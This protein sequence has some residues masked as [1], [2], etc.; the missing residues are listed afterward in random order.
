MGPNLAAEHDLTDMLTLRDDIINSPVSVGLARARTFTRVWQENPGAPWIV[1]KALA[2]REHLRTVGLFV[3]PCD[4]LAGSIAERPGAMPLFPE[5][6]I[7]ENRGYGSE[8]PERE[9]Y[10][11]GQVPREI[12][13]YWEHRNLWGRYRAYIKAVEGRS[14]ERT[15]AT[16]YKF[17]CNQGHLSPSYGEL[18]QVGLGGIGQKLR[19]RR[20]GE[21]DV[22]ALAFLTAAEH[23]LEGLSEWIRRY[24]ELLTGQ[25]ADCDDPARRA[26]LEEMARICAKVATQPPGGFREAMQLVWFVHQAVHIEGHGYS[27]TPDR[28]DQILYPF[29]LADKR[30]GRLDD[31]EAL[32]LCENFILKQRDNTF[33]GVE[34]NLTQG[35]VLS[36][37]T[38]DGE[39]LTN[40]LSWLFVT[41]CGNMSV[42]EPLVWIRWHANIDPDFFDHCLANIAGTT[43][44][45]LM[46]SDQAVPAML[47]EL[48]VSREDAFEY[49]PVGCNEIGIVGKAYFNPSAHVNYLGA[50][51]DAVTGG[52]G[53][54]GKRKPNPQLPDPAGLKTFD[55]LI[56]VIADRMRRGIQRTYDEEVQ[57]VG[58]QIRY[59]VTPL[60]SCFFDG[61]IDRARDMAQGTKYNILS[62]GGTNF[63]NMIDCL[64]AIR[65]V[66]FEKREASLAEIVE[67]CGANFEGHGPLRKKLLAAPKH[68][69]DDPG[70]DDL[71]RL[72]ERLRDEPMKEICRDP[73]D[74]SPF[75]NCHVVRSGAVLGGRWWGALPDGRLAGTPLAGSVA[76]SAGTEK[77]GPTA[78]LNSITKMNPVTSWQSGYNVNIR[79]QRSMLEVPANRTKIRAML[80]SYFDRGG[81][82]MQINCVDT[83]TLRAAQADPEQYRDIVVRVSGFSDHFVNLAKDIQEDVIARTEHGL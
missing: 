68:G 11:E 26:D 80:T 65:E 82:E 32:T 63:A 70:T 4:R 2:L 27:N 45:P 48:G 69:N 6:G 5:I 60:T 22:D 59:G 64:A 43:C 71:I 25:A 24:A 12:L 7:A 53:F 16:F 62:C 42:P 10:L 15:A 40:E 3:R 23:A 41:A 8:H 18:L 73:R 78:V 56:A 28:L 36:G 76:A 50:L 34:H 58:F 21:R 46:M 19:D 35:L 57:V 49:V 83:E 75:G 51:A 44:F 61:C 55:D 30:A 31:D 74:G 72:V 20:E 77:K 9:G 54:D 33:W 1:N 38:P 14:M 67:A 81:Q 79:F 52:R 39:D 13:D 17:I 37:S 66:V 29:Y 47:M